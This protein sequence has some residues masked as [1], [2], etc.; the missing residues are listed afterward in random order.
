MLSKEYEFQGR[1][2]VWE[3]GPVTDT[4]PVVLF[5][6]DGTLVDPAGSITGGIAFALEA[7]G[8]P[9]PEEHTLRKMVGPKLTD[10][11]LRYTA[12]REEQVSDVIAIY[13]GHYLEHGLKQSR[14]YPG[15]PE[16]LQVLRGEGYGL[17]VA[18]QKPEPLA[19]TLLSAMGLADSFDVIRG[20]HADETLMPGHPE[21]RAGKKEIIA[22]ALGTFGAAAQA[23][24]VGDRYQDVEGARANE[25]HC[26]G[27]AW[28]FAAE[29]ELESAGAL[30]VAADADELADVLRSYFRDASLEG[31]AGSRGS[32]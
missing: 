29:G 19:G 8:L 20:S 12:V 14:V 30:T 10:G 5:D 4:R 3:T 17:G 28:G 18:T 1:V 22:A 25:V 15:L 11:L 26:V 23:V 27:V 13:R 32:L 31:K 2:G 6:L 24:M 7:M 9:V 16:L 21:Y